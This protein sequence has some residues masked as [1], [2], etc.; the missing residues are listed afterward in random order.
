MPCKS[1]I[2]DLARL[3]CLEHGFHPTARTKYPFR[4]GHADNFM[5]LQQIDGISLQPLQ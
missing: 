5:K 2:A 1:D 3:F 4:V